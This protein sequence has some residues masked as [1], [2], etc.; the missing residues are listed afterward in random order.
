[1]Q[2]FSAACVRTDLEPLKKRCNNPKSLA[3]P[4]Q[5]QGPLI[6]YSGDLLTS[7]LIQKPKATS[8]ENGGEAYGRGS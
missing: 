8:P 2:I 7:S 6:F 5:T 3:R 1:E 4:Q